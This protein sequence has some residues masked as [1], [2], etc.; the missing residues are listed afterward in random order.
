M[1]LAWNVI[2]APSNHMPHDAPTP[3]E[4]R[5]SLDGSFDRS[6]AMSEG[7][8]DANEDPPQTAEP[9]TMVHTVTF[10]RHGQ[11]Y[12]VPVDRVLSVILYSETSRLFPLAQCQTHAFEPCCTRMRVVEVGRPTDGE[13]TT[14]LRDQQI[15]VCHDACTVVGFLIDEI[16]GLKKM[17]WSAIRPLVENQ[18]RRSAE[19]I[20]GVVNI[21]HRSAMLVDVGD[22]DLAE[23]RFK[24]KSDR[25]PRQRPDQ[26]PGAP[27]AGA[28][29]H[30]AR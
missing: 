3:D 23:E 18:L 29:T 25:L 27:R 2:S 1:R 30:A 14:A 4:F 19:H 6:G 24:R 12:A 28:D 10:L 13:T 22:G 9:P 20:F 26:A 5:I 8:T 7:T 11:L 16:H 21:G 17:R 15:L